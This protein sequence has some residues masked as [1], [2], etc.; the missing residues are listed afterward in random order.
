MTSAGTFLRQGRFDEALK[1]VEEAEKVN[2]TTEPNVW[3]LLGR[4]RLGQGRRE[5]AIEAFQKGLVADPTNT[6]CRLWLSKTFM[7]MEDWVISLGTLTVLT[8]GKGWNN[9][10]AW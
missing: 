6:D 8:Q 3:C 9:A 2:W 4:V 7:D 10:E 5:E 1:A